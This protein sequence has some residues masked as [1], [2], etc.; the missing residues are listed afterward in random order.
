[1]YLFFAFQLAEICFYNNAKYAEV[2]YMKRA[3][4]KPQTELMST[5]IPW[6]INKYLKLRII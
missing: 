2:F 5:N 1:M 4:L 3:D 6:L